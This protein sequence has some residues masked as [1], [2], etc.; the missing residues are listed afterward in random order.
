MGTLERAIIAKKKYDQLNLIIAALQ[1]AA[2]IQFEIIKELE[3]ED[4]LT[5][6]NLMGYN[7]ES[8]ND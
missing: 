8:N 1:D 6:D 2:A 5:F 7:T 4:V 3:D